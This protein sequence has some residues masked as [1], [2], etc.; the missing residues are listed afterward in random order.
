[1]NARVFAE[2]TVK[3]KASSVIGELLAGVVLGAKFKT[4]DVDV[5]VQ[6]NDLFFLYD[7]S[8]QPITIYYCYIPDV[9]KHI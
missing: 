5:I 1:M 9:Y 8:I 2:L 4:S 3:L 6:E 7:H